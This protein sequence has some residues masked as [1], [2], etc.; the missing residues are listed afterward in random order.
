MSDAVTGRSS[1]RLVTPLPM[2][3]RAKVLLVDDRAD[4]LKALEAALGGL[5]EDLVLARS[6][7]EAL[8]LLLA[9]EFAVILLD[10]NM[11]VMDGFETASLIRQRRNS[12]K[13]PIIFITA[14]NPV[15]NHVTRGY[16]LGAVDYI[17]SPVVP[18]VLQAKVAVFVDL[19]KRT[20]EVKRQSEWLRQEAEHRAASLEHRF[21]AL[22]NRL[23]VGVFRATQDG[24]LLNANPAYYRLL[25]LNQAVAAGSIS[26]GQFFIDEDRRT[27][28]MTRLERDG[29]VQES[30]VRQRRMDGN[31]LWASLSMAISTDPDGTT[32]ID[33]MIEDVTARQ[34]AE[35]ALM[36]KA[37]ELA[38]SNAELEQFAYIASHDLQEPLRMVSSYSSLVSSRYASRLDD[39]GRTFLGQIEQSAKRMQELVRGI[40]SFSKM[41]K[42]MA[43]SQLETGELIRKVLEGLDGEIVATQAE[44]S[45]SDLPAVN[46]DGVM[47]SQIFQNLIGN[48]LKFRSTQRR[49]RIAIAA[50]REGEWWRFSVADNGIGISADYHEKI[51]GLFQRLHTRDEYPGTGIGLA[52]CKKAVEQHGGTIQVVSRPDEGSVFSF[53]LP[54]GADERRP[55]LE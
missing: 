28:L 30:H 34:E 7:K 38:R 19:F 35:T 42:A 37:E 21:D 14:L 8:R 52:I 11:P 26:I 44:V 29:K 23:N 2:A 54:A 15:E 5:G 3:G 1:R 40:L 12:E 50:V 20:E 55:A 51:F 17:F 48:A 25:N 39:K 53:I 43:R 4:K 33:G 36:T 45:C 27:E 41:G 6:G 32:S 49:P 47:I 9:N 31:I 13:T 18:D 22:L 24:M 10:V 46:G 16:S